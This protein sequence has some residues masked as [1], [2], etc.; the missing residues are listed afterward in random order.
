MRSSRTRRHDRRS[1]VTTAAFV[2]LLLLAV[3]LAPA[4][5]SASPPTSPAGARSPLLDSATLGADISSDP[6]R[7]DWGYCTWWVATQRWVPWSGNAIEWYDN[8]QAMGYAVGY[9]PVPG[10]ILVR[11]SATWSGYGH[12]AYVEWV[13]GTTFGVSEMNVVG[14]GEVSWRTYDVESDPVPGLIGF[15]YWPY[16][17]GYDMSIPGETLVGSPSGLRGDYPY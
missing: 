15:I 14:F 8:A 7:F 3:L 10:A 2:P 17:S 1:I 6:D 12:V 4:T 5:A 16:D 9:E 11:H 13:D